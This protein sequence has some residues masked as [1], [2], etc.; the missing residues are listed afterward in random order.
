MH[1][2]PHT[3]MRIA[4]LCVAP[5]CRLYGTLRYSTVLYGTLRYSTVLYGTLRYS[6]VLYGTERSIPCEAVALSHCRRLNYAHTGQ[7]RRRPT[8]VR[9]RS[10]ANPKPHS[11]KRMPRHATPRHATP[12]HAT[13][14]CEQPPIGR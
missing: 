7:G 9:S 13:P 11:A 10:G 14:R 5:V 3:K 12:R 4:S 1:D 2:A 6:T 8:P